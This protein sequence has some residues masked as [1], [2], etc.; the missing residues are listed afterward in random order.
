MDVSCG[1]NVR[2]LSCE[3]NLSVRA[4]F[5]NGGEACHV[6]HSAALAWMGSE[7]ALQLV[8]EQAEVSW[9]CDI[10]GVDVLST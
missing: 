10:I 5:T 6:Q 3:Y 9:R 1:V 8:D 2:G 7:V 4:T